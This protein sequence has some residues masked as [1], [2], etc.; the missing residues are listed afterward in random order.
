MS[1][2]CERYKRLQLSAAANTSANHVLRIT[3]NTPEQNGECYAFAVAFE[4]RGD[5]HHQFRTSTGPKKPCSLSP[6]QFLW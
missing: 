2:A 1:H 4:N 3:Q 5:L 6:S